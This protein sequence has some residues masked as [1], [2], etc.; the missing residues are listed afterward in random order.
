M[1][2]YYDINLPNYKNLNSLK[3]EILCWLFKNNN[4][5]C[6][7]ISDCLKENFGDIV[8]TLNIMKLNGLVVTKNLYYGSNLEYYCL[9]KHGCFKSYYW[10]NRECFN[11]IYYT[12]KDKGFSKKSIV[13]FM[14]EGLYY[15]YITHKWLFHDHDLLDNYYNWCGRSDIDIKTSKLNRILKLGMGVKKI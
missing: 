14:Q 7:R 4:G 13:G 9:T 1:L 2:N 10:Y 15:Y 11:N 12:L 3:G 6:R 5:D 8:R